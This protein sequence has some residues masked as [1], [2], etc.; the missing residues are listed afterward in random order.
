[1]GDY[2]MELEFSNDDIVHLFKARFGRELREWLIDDEGFTVSPELTKRVLRTVKL[3][4]VT[5]GDLAAMHADP[6]EASPTAEKLAEPAKVTSII[7]R[8]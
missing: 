2:R 1:M 4:D 5:L 8:R 7:R 3:S 6:T